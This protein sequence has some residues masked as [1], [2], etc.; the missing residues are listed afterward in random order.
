MA[1]TKKRTIRIA[2]RGSRLA[3]AQTD[4]VA[5]MLGGLG[6]DTETVI[7]STKGD[8]NRKESLARIGGKGLFVRE[9]ENALLENRADIAVHSAKDLPSELSDGLAIAGVPETE[10]PA[11]CLVWVKGNADV[12]T[13][14]AVTGEYS[15]QPSVVHFHTSHPVI[16]TASPRRETELK[17][18]YPQA[19]FKLMRGNVDTRLQKLASGEY[20]ATILAEA[21]LKRLKPDLSGFEVRRLSLDEC[22]PAACQGIIAIECRRDDKEMLQVLSDHLITDPMTRYRFDIE[23]YML[24]LLNADCSMAV[25]ANAAFGEMQEDGDIALTLRAMLKGKHVIEQG[26]LSGF[27]DLCEKAAK[28]L[29]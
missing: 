21:G 22:I 20:D 16:G 11:D 17:H 14:Q 13:H 29:A 8:Q 3:M 18:L 23:R 9:I 2:T 1:D 7:I 5:T 19:E 6:Y 24:E 25:G 27:Q 4:L 26:L 12:F 28:E 10:S 15:D